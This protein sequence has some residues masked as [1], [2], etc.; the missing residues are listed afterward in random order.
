M[1][2]ELLLPLQ[3]LDELEEREARIERMMRH[4]WYETS[5]EY[6]VIREKELYKREGMGK[7]GWLTWADYCQERWGRDKRGIDLQIQRADEV[8]EMGKIFPISEDQLPSSVSHATALAKLEEP[9]DRATA[10]LRV[11]EHSEHRGITAKMV[12]A[13]VEKLKAELAKTYITLAEWESLSQEKQAD[14]LI[15]IGDKTFNETNENIEWAAWSW[16]PVTGCLHDCPYCYARDIAGRFYPHKFEPT[17]HPDRLTAP[18]NTKMGQPR[19]GGDIG[20]KGVFVCSMADLFGKWVPQEWI[21]AVLDSVR[22]APQWTFIFLTK[23][24]KRLPGITWPTNAWVGTTVDKQ[25]RVTAAEDAFE[26][27]DAKRLFLSCEPMLE[28]LT[29]SRLNVFDW[30]I[31]GGQSRSSQQPEFQPEWEWVE[32][33][34]KQARQAQCAVYWKDNLHVRPR[35]YPKDAIQ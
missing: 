32:H 19:W 16:N 22:Q 30:V 14:T 10:W 7:R 5:I 1:E 15:R 29:F 33:L 25:V 3:Y 13:E 24:P 35:E 11:L 20:Y 26:R 27:I 21:D 28:R 34:L 9:Q 6:K 18:Q 2:G 23:N 17:F 4:A 31:V 12:E 8:D